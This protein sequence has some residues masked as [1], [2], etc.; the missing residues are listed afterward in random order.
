MQLH[1]LVF[2]TTFLLNIHCVFG[3]SNCFLILSLGVSMPIK[4]LLKSS[5]FSWTR[6]SLMH[7]KTR[8]NFSIRC[9]QTTSG[10]RFSCGAGVGLPGPGGR[11]LPPTSSGQPRGT[12]GLGLS[13]CDRSVPARWSPRPGSS[14][15]PGVSQM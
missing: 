1:L 8:G 14:L 13:S 3:N 9:K 15:G 12:G 7:S 4:T 5:Y 10:G 6:I 2:Q 11:S